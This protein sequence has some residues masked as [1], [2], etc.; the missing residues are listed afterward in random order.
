LSNSG[1]F[2]TKRLENFNRTFKALIKSH[3]RKN[4]QAKAEFEKQV[5][6]LIFLLRSDPRPRP[7]FGGMEPWPKG[8]HREEWELRKLYFDMPGYRGEAGEGR[9]IYMIHEE[10]STAYLLWIY[11]H[12][13]FV[14]RPPDKSLRRLVNEAYEEAKK[15]GHEGKTE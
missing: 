13:E 12:A 3:Y 14:G 4:R 1:S 5:A 6:G 7:P 2:R 15:Q 9:L 8:S 11:T 10:E